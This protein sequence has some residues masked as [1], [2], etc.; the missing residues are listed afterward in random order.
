M[1]IDRV[2]VS[3]D[4]CNPANTYNN[5]IKIYSSDT[6]EYCLALGYQARQYSPI[7]IL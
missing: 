5:T 7:S 3:K 2:G 4:A 1:N 6:G